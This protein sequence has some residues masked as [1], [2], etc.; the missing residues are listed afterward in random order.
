M[1]NR[2]TTSLFNRVK[3]IIPQYPFE[4]CLSL[5]YGIFIAL[6]TNNEIN[7]ER[8]FVPSLYLFLAI[9]ISYIANTWCQEH[10]KSRAIYY[11]S[12]IFFAVVLPVS[13]YYYPDY[14]YYIVAFI[15][16]VLVYLINGK[17]RSNADLSDRATRLVKSVF[18]SGVFLSVIFALLGLIL[19]SVSYLLFKLDV[20]IY[21]YLYG[22]LG[23]VS[24]TLL[25]TY[26]NRLE[27]D[28][29]STIFKVLIHY[30]LTTS[31]LIYTLILY[32]Y[33]AKI[34]VKW[35]L[36]EGNLSYITIMYISLFFMTRA[37]S[38]LMPEFFVKPFF[39]YASLICL[40]PLVL[41]WIGAM[42]RITEY[43]FT[44]DRCYLLVVAIIES[45]IVLFSLSQKTER[46]WLYIL[47]S[48]GILVAVTYVPYINVKA[49]SDCSQSTRPENSKGSLNDDKA[50]EV[51]LDIKAESELSVKGYSQMQLL[52]HPYEIKNDSLNIRLTKDSVL[53]NKQN[54]II[55]KEALAEIYTKKLLRIGYTHIAD[56][57]PAAKRELLTISQDPYLLVFSE[58]TLRVNK[59]S[60]ISVNY[61]APVILFTK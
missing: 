5:V 23:S 37:V 18:V 15:V 32:I 40:A 48:I 55:C 47:F 44:I 17:V 4:V 54:E 42:V 31:L 30:I 50:K 57:S 43:G 3:E 41:L 10:Q 11:I 35:E 61:Y 49:I 28:Y 56:P 39:R 9:F 25:F 24:F 7:H 51:Y 1:L 58:I 46:Y 36:P 6:I 34:V 33:I 45:V 2:I 52:Y 20:K 13:G 60:M 12:S 26:Y 59:D 27:C 22:I 29:Q 8:Y 19:L 21:A 38:G 53:I 16:A 14:H